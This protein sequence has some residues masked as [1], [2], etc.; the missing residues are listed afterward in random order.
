MKSVVERVLRTFGF[1]MY[2]L[3]PKP[4]QHLRTAP[5][6]QETTVTLLGEEFRIPDSRSFYWSFNE[7]F[8]REIYRFSSS[9]TRPII[10]DCGSNCG[11]SIVYFKSLFPESIITGVE[12]D[13]E[14]FRL[15]KHNIVNRGYTDVTLLQG[16]ISN[17]SAPISF[18]HE[19][20]DGG[21]T[22]PLDIHKSVF[23]VEPVHLDDLID[24]PIDFLK[25]DIEGSEAEA[26]CLSEK[27]GNVGQLFI[28]YHSFKN[29]DQALGDM[30]NRLSSSGF[31]YYIHTQFCSDRPLT[32][33]KL[34]L[35]MDLQLNIFANR[36]E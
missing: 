26:I 9:S 25:M 24:E 28:E 31:R 27:L 20:A 12:P 1:E 18:Y 30:L 34:Q 36:Q 8:V 3:K 23:D 14:L 11:T 19:G 6:Y 21:R 33:E 7:I 22:R 15:L 32:E 5:R 10:I 13:P 17:S 35:G 2:R 29:S 16:A 4:Y